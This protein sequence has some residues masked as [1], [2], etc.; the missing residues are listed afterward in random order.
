MQQDVQTDATCNINQCCVP[1]FDSCKRRPPPV[2]SD[3]SLNLGWSLTATSS[4]GLFPQ[5]MGG[6]P[7]PF[8]EGKALG[9]RLRLREVGLYNEN[10]IFIR[11]PVSRQKCK[12]S[13]N[14][15]PFSSPLSMLFWV[16][17]SNTSPG[18]HPFRP[19]D[20]ETTG[21]GDESAVGFSSKGFVR[22]YSKLCN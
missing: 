18:L 6:A 17:L 9:T 2:L 3:Q 7:H 1:Q 12:P 13:L 4:P 21:S 19:R 11:F 5:K 14:K 15:W 20:Q 8:F 10:N 16:T 22:R